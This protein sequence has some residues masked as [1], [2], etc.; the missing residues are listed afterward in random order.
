MA[1]SCFV[2]CAIDTSK[3]KCFIVEGGGGFNIDML[4]HHDGFCE[5]QQNIHFLEKELEKK[6]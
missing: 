3:L 5:G 1:V 6:E 4:M 2:L